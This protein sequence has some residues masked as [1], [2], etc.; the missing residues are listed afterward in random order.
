[1]QF[2]KRRIERW[3]A[4]N[5]VDADLDLDGLK[6]TELPE[7][8]SNC[9]KLKCSNNRLTFLPDLPS[10]VELYCH[11]NEL[12]QLPDIHNCTILT[13]YGNKLIE[14]PELPYC[15]YLNCAGN[16][17]ITLPNMS[18][19]NSIWC[20][21]NNKYFYMTPTQAKLYMYSRECVTNYPLFATKIQKT[22]RKYK[23]KQI[24]VELSKL[25]IKN[26]SLVISWYV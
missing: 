9:K 12:K 13:C 16:Q 25:Y 24:F 4:K 18:L 1:M 17:L 14:L 11:N 10:C 2:A 15:K 20:M 6:L 23:Q 8:P 19:G 7:I 26:V 22:Y 5:D 3:I 21:N